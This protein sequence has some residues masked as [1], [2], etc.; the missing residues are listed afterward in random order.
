[1]FVQVAAHLVGCSLPLSKV[2]SQLVSIYSASNSDLTE[3]AVRNMVI[4]LASRRSFAA[5]DGESLFCAKT[6]D[7]ICW[8]RCR[9]VL[10]LPSVR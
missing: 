4:D 1:M 2:T 10:K 9:Q 8:C 6:L 7:S 5:K 3:T